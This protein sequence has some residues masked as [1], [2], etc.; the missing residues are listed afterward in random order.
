MTFISVGLCEP[1]ELPHGFEKPSQECADGDPPD[2]QEGA[3]GAE[4]EGDGAP[5]SGA[6]GTFRPVFVALKS[7]CGAN[8]ENHES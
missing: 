6:S 8:I 3:G 1:L 2:P 5:R 4:K 7:G